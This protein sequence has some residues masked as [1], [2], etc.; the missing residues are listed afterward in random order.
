MVCAATKSLKIKEMK[1]KV[2]GTKGL[3]VGCS[4]TEGF[5]NP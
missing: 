1:I 3:K 4:K 2:T 5:N